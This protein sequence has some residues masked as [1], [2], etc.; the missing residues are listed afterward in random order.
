MTEQDRIDDMLAALDDTDTEARLL[1]DDVPI[2][3]GHAST[4]RDTHTPSLDC[5]LNRCAACEDHFNF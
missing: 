1:C 3:S 5:A 2:R 4:P